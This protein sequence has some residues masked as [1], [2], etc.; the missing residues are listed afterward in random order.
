[1]GGIPGDEAGVQQVED[2]Q[3]LRRF[4]G[5]SLDLFDR[6]PLDAQ[7]LNVDILHFCG[8]HFSGCGLGE[9]PDLVD[10]LLHLGKLAHE[11]VQVAPRISLRLH[12][13]IVQAN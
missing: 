12:R 3:L 11:A 4:L 1:M 8:L 9:T 2:R 10:V 7:S 6:L 5:C 13:G